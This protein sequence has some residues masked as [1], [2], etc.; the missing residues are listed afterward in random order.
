VDY[1]E[2]T[3]NTF[4]VS[5]DNGPTITPNKTIDYDE[6]TQDVTIDFVYINDAVSPALDL[7]SMN[8]VYTTYKLPSKNQ[9]EELKPRYLGANSE[10]GSRYISKT[11][12]LDTPANNVVVR[13]DK[14]EPPETEISVYMKYKTPGSELGM[15]DSEYVQLSSSRNIGKTTTN[16]FLTDEYTFP[17]TLP[18]ISSFSVKIVF[19][20]SIGGSPKKYPKI[21]NLTITAV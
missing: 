13:F 6:D 1:I 9:S 7:N 14:I 5:L 10:D 12:N 16:S 3:P 18:E 21:K 2:P 8:S 11:V 15:S 20:S 4:N 17:G 19:S